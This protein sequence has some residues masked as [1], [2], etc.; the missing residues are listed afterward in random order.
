MIIHFQNEF[1]NGISKKQNGPTFQDQ[2]L[3]EITSD[4]IKN[5]DDKVAKFSSTIAANT[6]PMISPCQ[7]RKTKPWFDEDCQAAIKERNNANKLS[8]N[9]LML[10][11]LNEHT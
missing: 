10:R 4:L 1:R 9:I 7:K 6:I 2:C 11:I 3:T 8:K 5:A